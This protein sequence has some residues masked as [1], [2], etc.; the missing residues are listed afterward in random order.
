MSVFG[1]PARAHMRDNPAVQLL[2]RE[3][4][5]A[6][7]ELEDIAGELEKTRREQK[8]LIAQADELTARQRKRIHERD[9]FALILEDLLGLRR[10]EL[11]S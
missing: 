10:G 6:K 11:R 2:Q 4:D 5:A 1:A 9:A 8:S 3:L 7:E